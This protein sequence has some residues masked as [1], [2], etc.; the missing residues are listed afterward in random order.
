[1]RLRRSVPPPRTVALA[2][3]LAGLSYA[4]LVMGN[5]I[6][7]LA[8]P[9]RGSVVQTRNQVVTLLSVTPPGESGS[10]STVV[11]TAYV[12]PS[13]ESGF[14]GFY[15]GPTLFSWGRYESSAV[16]LPMYS[17]TTWLTLGK[18]SLR[19]VF[20]PDAPEAVAAYS[21]SVPYVIRPSSA[22]L[23]TPTASA[24]TQDTQSITVRVPRH[25]RQGPQPEPSRE[26]TR[27]LAEDFT[28]APRHSAGGN[29]LPF[30]GSGTV[31]M[32]WA[33]LLLLATGVVMTRR[34]RR[35]PRAVVRRADLS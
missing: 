18:H 16:P 19:A 11:L 35:Y 10:G 33:G 9:D 31:T 28:Q 25:H 29:L 7:A 15:D 8:A 20:M 4:A 24:V 2:T 5:A 27:V 30:T 26:P 17:S 12:S 21:A 22:V 1:M 23:A 32:V 3:M 13:A 34:A 14:V 6:P